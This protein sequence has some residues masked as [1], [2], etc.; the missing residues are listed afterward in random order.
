MHAKLS[1][2]K[3]RNGSIAEALEMT[4]LRFIENF[5]DFFCLCPQSPGKAKS[6]TADDQY[7][8]ACYYHQDPTMVETKAKLRKLTIINMDSTLSTLSHSM[9]F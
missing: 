3:Y 7:D 4:V 5:H 6:K 8:N 1:Q 9:Q 2:Q